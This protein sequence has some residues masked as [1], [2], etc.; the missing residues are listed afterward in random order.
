M[1]LLGLLE[2]LLLHGLLLYV[3]DKLMQYLEELKA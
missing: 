2:I 1:T 3:V